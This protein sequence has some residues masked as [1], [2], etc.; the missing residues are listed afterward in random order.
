MAKGNKKDRLEPCFPL[1]EVKT[2][3]KEGRYIIAQQALKSAHDDFEWGAEEII[4]AILFLSEKHLHK[5]SVCYNKSHIMMDVYKAC[6]MGENI[7]IHFYIDDD[8]R[9]L[10]IGSFKE[11]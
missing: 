7:Y 1:R 11:I 9:L 6:L 4:K 8:D 2:L 5:R 3:A 10:I